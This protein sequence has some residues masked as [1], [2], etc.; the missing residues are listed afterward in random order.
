MN[1][2]EWCPSTNSRRLVFLSPFPLWTPLGQRTKENDINNSIIGSC[3]FHYIFQ[4]H[5]P[6]RKIPVSSLIEHESSQVFKT[7]KANTLP[8]AS[9]PSKRINTT[10]Y[11]SFQTSW[12]LNFSTNPRR[13]EFG[14]STVWY[15]GNQVGTR[16]NIQNMKKLNNG[17]VFDE[18]KYTNN[19]RCGR[20]N[21]MNVT[22][23][24]VMQ[25]YNKGWI[26]VEN[27]IFFFLFL[28]LSFSFFGF[29]EIL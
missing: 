16:D 23:V 5:Q 15:P 28:I 22:Y 18:I 14:N 8:K 26:H 13:W 27:L 12:S 9:V 4:L 3:Q 1:I 10:I 6:E 19:A 7:N 25:R 21:Q 20:T 29:G 17:L 2:N 11:R 24:R